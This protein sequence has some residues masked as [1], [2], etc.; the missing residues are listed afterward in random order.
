MKRRWT[1]LEKDIVCENYPRCNKLEL[2]NLL[3]GRTWSSISS[4]AFRLR[5]K[6]NERSHAR[7]E[8]NMSVLLEENVTSYYWMGFLIADASIS[9]TRIKLDLADKDRNHVVEFCRFVKCNNHRS[10]KNGAY[11]VALMDK[12]N[13]SKIIKKFK[14]L[15]RKTYNPPD[16][17]WMFD[18]DL[19]VSF[20][21]GFIDGDGSI[22]KQ[23]KRKD[24]I[25]T[26]KNYASWLNNLQYMVNRVS[27]L[28][29]VNSTKAIIDNQGYAKVRIAN[30]IC[31]KSLKRKIIKLKL[32]VLQR[33][34][35]RIDLNFTGKYEKSTINNHKIILLNKEG[36]KNSEIANVLNLPYSCITAK[37]KK[38]NIVKN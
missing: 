37:M 28:S 21:V 5:L 31:L 13:I 16:L 36:Y 27:D 33:K 8:S 29:N 10:L 7:V 14:L 25:L 12:F 4:T 18:D 30:S 34:W 19:F 38:L 2:M 15:P 9:N 32:P 35:N 20:F 11:G 23:F 6:F 17:T 26:I 3:P 22:V 1:Q 24:C